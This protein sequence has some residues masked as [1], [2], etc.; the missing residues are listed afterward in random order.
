M[1]VGEGYLPAQQLILRTFGELTFCDS[2]RVF[3]SPGCIVGIRKLENDPWRVG[4]FL[5][6]G[7]EKAEPSLGVSN[8]VVEKS[9]IDSVGYWISL[10]FVVLQSVR[11][12][13]QLKLCQCAGRK[14]SHNSIL[15]QTNLSD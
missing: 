11:P 13:W 5:V 4:P 15:I 8:A 7:F 9:P 14:Q 1:E 10:V 3:R 2:N 6:S 12:L